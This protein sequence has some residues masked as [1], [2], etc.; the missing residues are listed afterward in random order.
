MNSLLHMYLFMS[1]SDSGA[2]L[3][4]NISHEGYVEARQGP[5]QDDNLARTGAAPT[6]NKAEESPSRHLS[7]IESL[8]TRALTY[9]DK[10][11]YQQAEPLL[12]KPS[13]SV[14]SI[15]NPP[16]RSFW[17]R[18]STTWLDSITTREST[19]TWSRCYSVR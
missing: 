6:E 15:G 3:P 14:K 13:L 17:L 4:P 9:Q 18:P 11:Q 10:G 8:N 2:L 5:E 16:N 1:L 19:A 7:L 12:R